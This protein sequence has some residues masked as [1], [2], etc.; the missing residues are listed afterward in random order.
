MRDDLLFQVLEQAPTTA[1]AFDYLKDPLYRND[2]KALLR[3]YDILPLMGKLILQEIEDRLDNADLIIQSLKKDLPKISDWLSENSRQVVKRYKED[4][5]Q[6]ECATIVGELHLQNKM[7]DDLSRKVLPYISK[8]TRKLWKSNPKFYDV[9]SAG[10]IRKFVKKYIALLAL[11]ENL[12]NTENLI[13]Y[14]KE[15]IDRCIPMGQ[16]EVGQTFIFP[17]AE[18]AMDDGGQEFTYEGLAEENIPGDPENKNIVCLYR[19][20]DD[21]ILIT[22]KEENALR[23]VIPTVQI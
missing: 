23:A 15:V 14:K 7:M 10:R 21:S 18:H 12:M 9:M 22:Y 11:Y 8:D 16:L 1:S 19:R 2:L 17:Y 3:M 4:E 6:H 20:I 5:E 13:T